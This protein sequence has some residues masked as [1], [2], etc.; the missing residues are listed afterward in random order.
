MIT[1]YKIVSIKSILD[2][3]LTFNDHIK[4]KFTTV[5]K[6]TS[7]LRKL[8]HYIP[9][10]SLVTI[11]KTFI[12]PHLDYTDVIFSK[13]SNATFSNRIESTQFNAALAITR[14][15]RGTSKEKLYQNLDLRQL[16]GGG[17]FEDFVVFIKFWIIKHQLIFTV[18]FPHQIGIIIHV[19]IPK[20]DRFSAEQKLLVILF[21]LRQLEN[22]T[23]LLPPSVKLLHIQY[24]AKHF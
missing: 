12:R 14:T 10:D 3:K 19:S 5:N 9:R 1:R 21:C 20:L 7:T 15:I 16:R 18:Y 11:F 4:S 24:F 6:L 2:E 13:P 23:K 22:G 8:Y 17:G